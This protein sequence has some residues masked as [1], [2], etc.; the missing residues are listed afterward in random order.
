MNVL[1]E[2]PRLATLFTFAREAE[3]ER[4]SL[5]E[6]SLGGEV[7]CAPQ[8][9][10]T[11]QR[12]L[13]QDVHLSSEWFVHRPF[14]QHVHDLFAGGQQSSLTHEFARTAQGLD[15]TG[16]GGD[17]LLEHREHRFGGELLRRGTH[18]LQRGTQ[19]AALARVQPL[20]ERLDSGLDTRERRTVHE[21]RMRRLEHGDSFRELACT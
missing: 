8:P 2:D 17:Q 6:A 10:F 4:G 7:P 13:I 3:Q 1:Q 21:D 5:C 12:M 9:L 11:V 18:G 20:G 15:R 16:V 14:L 19:V